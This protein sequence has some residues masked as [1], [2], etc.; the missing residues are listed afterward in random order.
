M[1]HVQGN[2]CSGAHIQEQAS[3]LEP[4]HGCVTSWG[5]S[6]G[7]LREKRDMF[8]TQTVKGD[9]AT[10]RAYIPFSFGPRD[11]LGQRM[12]MMEVRAA[13]A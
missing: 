10:Q 1:A 8:N 4:V 5:F 11:C 13:L 7:P 9:D 12:A 6:A 2:S 3:E